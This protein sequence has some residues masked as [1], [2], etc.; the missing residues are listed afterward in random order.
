MLK[1]CTKCRTPK[2]TGEF[3][4]NKTCNDGL[5]LWCKSCKFAYVSLHPESKE[6]RRIR[7]RI[8]HR[9]IDRRY[10]RTLIDA[11]KHVFEGDVLTFEQYKVKLCYPD[12]SLRSCHYCHHSVGET[13]SGLDRIECHITYTNENTV[14]SCHGCNVWKK[15]KRTYRETMDRFKPM[16]D[17]ESNKIIVMLAN[18]ADALT[19]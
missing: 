18:F 2:D 13:G 10:K 11:K 7:G 3:Y 12:G 15:N 8:L 6:N 17:A 5:H 4:K 9:Q 16:R 19:A 1:T 14:P